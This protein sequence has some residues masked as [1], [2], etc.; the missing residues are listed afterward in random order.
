MKTLVGKEDRLVFPA[1]AVLVVLAEQSQ[2]VVVLVAGD[3]N[4]Y[5]EKNQAIF[6]VRPRLMSGNI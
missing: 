1:A 2:R 6:Q 3:Q 5:R 4:L